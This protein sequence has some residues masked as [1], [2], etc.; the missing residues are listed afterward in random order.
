[1]QRMHPGY[2]GGRVVF[3]ILPDLMESF[4]GTDDMLPIVALPNGF[5]KS[6]GDCGLEG[7]Y[8]HGDGS[9]MP[10]P[11]V[12]QDENAM[13]MIRHY[14]ERVQRDVREMLRNFIPTSRNNITR[15]AKYAAI[16]R[17]DGYEIGA[18][19]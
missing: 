1:M 8:H 18:R 11:Y 14:Y 7:A 9:G 16:A 6:F 3:D 5:S 12:L 13:D 10:D 2:Q 17:A 4:F 15:V 19:S